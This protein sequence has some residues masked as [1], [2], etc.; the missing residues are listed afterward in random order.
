MRK[1]GPIV[2]SLVLGSV[3]ACDGAAPPDQEPASTEMPEQAAAPDTAG[4]AT[5]TAGTT[6]NDAA[7]NDTATADESRSAPQ[8]YD[9]LNLMRLELE[10]AYLDELVDRFDFELQPLP[11]RPTVPPG[12]F[13]PYERGL[14]LRENWMNCSGYLTNNP[15]AGFCEDQPP[16]NWRPFRFNGENYFLVPLGPTA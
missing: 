3:A 7:G 14:P 15:A 2:L 6:V 11:Q 1:L 10:Q 5:A 8:P 12:D 16:P 4:D 9:R 13:Q